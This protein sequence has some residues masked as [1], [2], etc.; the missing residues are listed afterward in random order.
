MSNSDT[1]CSVTFGVSQHDPERCRA[2]DSI[3]RPILK[4]FLRKQCLND[5][6]ANDLVYEIF[7]KLLKKLHTCDREKCPSRTWVFSAAHNT[8]FDFA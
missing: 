3:Y 4:A 2:F 7:V 1:R 5:S 6:D 8:L